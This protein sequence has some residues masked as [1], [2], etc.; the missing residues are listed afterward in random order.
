MEEFQRKLIDIESIED[1]NQLELNYRFWLN[2][3]SNVVD[4]VE[5]LN[6][7]LKLDHKRKI[8]EGV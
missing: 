5:K 4:K 2:S 8:I 3:H 1:L 6:F 7:Q